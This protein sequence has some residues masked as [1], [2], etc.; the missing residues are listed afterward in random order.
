VCQNGHFYRTFG[1]MS[2]HARI[3]F[4][5]CCKSSSFR[6]CSIVREQLGRKESAETL[7]WVMLGGSQFL[8]S[9]PVS[10]IDFVNAGMHGIPKLAVVNLAK[11][12]GAPM[13]DMAALLHVS[14]RTLGGKKDMDILDPISS[15]LSIEIASTIARGLRLFED[16][17][18]LNRWLHKQNRVLQGQKHFDLLNTP[19]GIKLV[20]QILGR[21]EEGV[22]T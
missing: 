8:P 12:L 6:Y 10:E 7:I 22:Y 2:F 3:E 14:Y 13:K 19:T 5:N 11:I 18:K 16:G 17:D 1:K 4:A 9:K 21:I 15:S 20:N